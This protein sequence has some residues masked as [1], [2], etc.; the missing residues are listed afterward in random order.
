MVINLRI[1]GYIILNLINYSS[2]IMET[3]IIKHFPEFLK[4]LD[5]SSLNPNPLFQTFLLIPHQNIMLSSLVNVHRPSVILSNHFVTS[6]TIQ[7]GN[8]SVNWPL[9]VETFR[10]S[11]PLLTHI[12]PP[13]KGFLSKNYNGH[14]VFQRFNEL[15][16]SKQFA[17]KTLIITHI[18]SNH[19]K[20]IKIAL[21]SVR[22][23]DL[24]YFLQ[25]EK[26][27]HIKYDLYSF[28]EDGDYLVKIEAILVDL[29]CVV[30]DKSEKQVVHENCENVSVE[31]CFK[32]METKYKSVFHPSHKKLFVNLDGPFEAVCPREKFVAFGKSTKHSVLLFHAYLNE[33]LV[34]ELFEPFKPNVTCRDI[35][36]QSVD[37]LGLEEGQ[38][39]VRPRISNQKGVIYPVFR[40]MITVDMFSFN[41]LTC[42]GVWQ[43]LD[44]YAYLRPFHLNAW[45]GIGI[46]FAAIV[47]MMALIVELNEVRINMVTY[48]NTIVYT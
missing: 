34:H 33:V 32:Q 24:I 17:T 48:F 45:I 46:A 7:E 20:N 23:I 38:I 42:D 4:S 25:T 14:A 16:V 22:R 2:Q 18:K 13:A 1:L 6:A 37:N 39:L 8:I 30:C 47:I 31:N 29:N 44:F 10:K 15:F 35:F 27:K 3:I 26:V 43:G 40:N 5:H 11:Y 9:W 36:A 41:F 28:N 12:Y 21:D 19:I